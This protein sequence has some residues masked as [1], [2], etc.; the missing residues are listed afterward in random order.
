MPKIVI[1]RVGLPRSM[2]YTWEIFECVIKMGMHTLE[3]RN[4]PFNNQNHEI[5]VLLSF[6]SGYIIGGVQFPHS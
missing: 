6:S 2:A 1:N 3:H 4:M 5:Y